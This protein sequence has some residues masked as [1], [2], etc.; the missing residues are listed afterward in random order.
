MVNFTFIFSD[1]KSQKKQK[2]NKELVKQQNEK[3]TLTFEF[4]LFCQRILQR[5]VSFLGSL[6][7]KSQFKTSKA[8]QKQYQTGLNKRGY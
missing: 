5:S 1:I 4:I 3:K 2:T 6:Q 7:K 8:K